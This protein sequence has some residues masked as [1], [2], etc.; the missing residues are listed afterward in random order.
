[1]CLLPQITEAKWFEIF[2]LLAITGTCVSLAVRTSPSHQL[3][4]ERIVVFVA[5]ADFYKT[6]AS[7]N[8]G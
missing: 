6:M 5:A 7:G 2:I 8:Y 4:L 3:L 1:M